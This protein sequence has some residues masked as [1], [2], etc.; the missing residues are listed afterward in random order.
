MKRQ[1]VLL[2]AA[3]G[4]AVL[5]TAHS[6]R[7]SNQPATTHTW[8]VEE[9]NDSL[10]IRFSSTNVHY[11][12]LANEGVLYLYT[13]FKAPL[14]RGTDST[15]R[16][17]LNLSLVIDRSGSMDGAKL[18]YAKKAA[19]F[20]VDH[21]TPDDYLSIVIYDSE[22]KTLFPSQRVTNK[23]TLKNLIQQLRSGSSTN[24]SGGMLEGY[25]QVQ[26]TYKSGYVNRVLLMSDG[27]AN[28]GITD[29]LSLFNIVRG[30]LREQGISISTFGVGLDYNEDLMQGLAENGNGNYYFIANPEEIPG[31]FKKELNGLLY[32]YAQNTSIHITLPEGVKFSRLYGLTAERA[33]DREVV[34]NLRDVFSEETKACVLKLTY[35]AALQAPLNFSAKFN[36]NNMSR[37]AE[38]TTAL[39]SITLTQKTDTAE[40]AKTENEQ[41]WQQV[42]LFESNDLLQQTIQAVDKRKFDEA[43]KIAVQNEAYF[44]K[45]KQKVRFNSELAKQDSINVNYSKSIEKSKTMQESELKYYQKMNKS[46]NYN[47][48]S[49]K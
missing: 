25:N 5:L 1:L 33:D 14:F 16:T 12:Y 35:S 48:K 49:K 40:L 42:Y 41:V 36:W 24:L 19:M 31:I 34:I 15:Q 17:P 18:E 9:K 45:A 30:K 23:V 47:I 8:A 20:V 29:N 13:E 38:N 22:V 3:A 46:G 37:N 6:N 21:V 11:N 44:T 10:N 4:I 26:A 32:L 28:E 2:A 7:V 27:L 43:Q 39:K